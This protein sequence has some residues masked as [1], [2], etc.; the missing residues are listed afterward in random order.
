M[1]EQ[2]TRLG[3]GLLLVL[4]ATLVS[5][6][7]KSVGVLKLRIVTIE[8]HDD[9]K[10]TIATSIDEKGAKLI[11]VTAHPVFRVTGEDSTNRLVLSC[12]WPERYTIPPSQPTDVISGCPR[13]FHV[14]QV[15]TFRKISGG[16]AA[17]EASGVEG[18]SESAMEKNKQLP[19]QI[20]EE[21]TVETKPCR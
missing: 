9:P 11:L 20:V 8:Q 10:P 17:F 3:R 13:F 14:G 19:F 1:E 4:V 21:G 5:S 16:W 15:V 18:V 7:E 12:E 2:M 6:Q